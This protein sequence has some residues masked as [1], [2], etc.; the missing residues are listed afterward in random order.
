MCSADNR[1]SHA[2]SRGQPPAVTPRPSVSTISV[3]SPRMVKSLLLKRLSLCWNAPGWLTE[4]AAFRPETLPGE[5][6]PHTSDREGQGKVSMSRD[7]WTKTT[8]PASQQ[9][10]MHLYKCTDWGIHVFGFSSRRA[11]TNQPGKQARPT[12]KVHFISCQRWVHCSQPSPPFL[13]DSIQ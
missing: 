12:F 9:G 1:N 3:P 4:A 10:G 5:T 13:T 6:T 7:K 8:Q 11:A 2:S